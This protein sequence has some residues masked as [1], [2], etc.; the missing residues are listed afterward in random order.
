MSIYLT[1]R[2]RNGKRHGP[3][4][5]SG[6]QYLG[7][8]TVQGQDVFLKSNGKFV[9]QLIRK[10]EIPKGTDSPFTD[11]EI[12]IRN[13][14]D[15]PLLTLLNIIDLKIELEPQFSGKAIDAAVADLV[16]KGILEQVAKG[17][18]RMVA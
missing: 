1:Y 15:L 14:F 11:I 2:L 16:K 6:N 8:V 4:A 17:N 13:L 10:A 3:Y 7:A 5:M 18:Y 9:G 12:A